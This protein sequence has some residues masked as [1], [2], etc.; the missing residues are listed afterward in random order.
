[1]VE[2]LEHALR[3]V[4]RD[5]MVQRGHGIFQQHREGVHERG[6]QVDAASVV[7]RTHHEDG[8]GRNGQQRPQAMGDGVRDLLPQRVLADVAS[9]VR[10]AGRRMRHLVAQRVHAGVVVRLELRRRPTGSGP[11]LCF[12]HDRRRALGTAAGAGTSSAFGVG[13]S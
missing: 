1:M 9:F 12:G 3:T 8:D 11:V 13:C 5:G 10:G 6:E 2:Y 7:E 4:Y